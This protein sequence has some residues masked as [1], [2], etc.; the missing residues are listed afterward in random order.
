M[1]TPAARRRKVGP[2]DAIVYEGSPDAPTLVLFHGYGADG[3]DLAP[4][5][6]E[7]GLS[8]PVNAAFP[9]APLTLSFDGM[10]GGRAWFPIDVERLQRAQMTGKPVDWS[11]AE[12]GGLAEARRAAEEFLAALGAPPARLILGGFSQ[13]AM[14]AVDLALRA[15]QA[16]LGL[17][18]LSGNLINEK[19]W[20][21]LAARRKGL[22]FLQS[23]GTSDPILGYAGAKRLAEVLKAGGLDGEL[24]S[25]DGGHGIP[26]SVIEALGRFVE[27]LSAKA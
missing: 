1:R 23:H 10:P 26:V 21:E 9:D 20:A 25:F 12:P 2:L 19:K 18:V 15:A 4:L 27:E 11:A 5:A 17:A 7:L 16:P 8:K 3:A 13:G 22:R 24:I 14:L 6:A